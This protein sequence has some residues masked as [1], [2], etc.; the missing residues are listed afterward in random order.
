[1]DIAIIAG[2]LHIR[3]VEMIGDCFA[4]WSSACHRRA[5]ADG[6]GIADRDACRLTRGGRMIERNALSSLREGAL[7]RRR[8]NFS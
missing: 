2:D 3:D 8:F 5:A 6:R 7:S 4:G 1:M